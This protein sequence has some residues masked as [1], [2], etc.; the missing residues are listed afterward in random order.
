[1]YENRAMKS[2]EFV[3]R[4]EEERRNKREKWKG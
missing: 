2:I 3:L 1:M 4:R